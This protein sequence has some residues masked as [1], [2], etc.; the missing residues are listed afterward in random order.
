MSVTSATDN[1]PRIG[2]EPNPQPSEDGKKIDK[3]DKKSID[4]E[5]MPSLTSAPNLAGFYQQ[6]LKPIVPL[7]ASNPACLANA[8]VMGEGAMGL[9]AKQ[10]SKILLTG[11]A[12]PAAVPL[13]GA[14]FGASAAIGAGAGMLGGYVGKVVGEQVCP[15]KYVPIALASAPA[16]D[17]SHYGEEQ[18]EVADASGPDAGVPASP[19]TSTPAPTP[20]PVPTSTPA[21]SSTPA[22]TSTTP[23][24]CLP[25]TSTKSAPTASSMPPSAPSKSPVPK[26]A[27]PLATPKAQAGTFTPVG[28]K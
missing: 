1:K 12:G 15:P 26:K 14:I 13:Q 21:P 5:A 9:A 8:E 11:I 10:G 25:P 20:A 28:G 23:L 17:W 27:E 4:L 18:P 7:P 6:A 24:V 2:F 3:K 19:S 16:P 22:A